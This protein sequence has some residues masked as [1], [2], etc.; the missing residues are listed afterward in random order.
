MILHVGIPRS[1]LHSSVEYMCSRSSYSPVVGILNNTCTALAR[2]ENYS[3]DLPEMYILFYSI[4][5]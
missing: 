1:T 2:V 5:C 3:L 4:L